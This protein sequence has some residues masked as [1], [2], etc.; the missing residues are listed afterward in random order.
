LTA[1]GALPEG[2]IYC[3]P[4]TNTSFL[5]GF[6]MWSRQLHMYLDSCFVITAVT[7]SC[8]SFSGMS[9]ALLA[10]QHP[11]YG[12]YNAFFPVILYSILGTSRHVSM[13][14]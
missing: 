13:G 10:G 2:N 7:S 3:M 6:T 1:Q 5:D 4:T 11:V 14:M 9:Y 12:L 8:C